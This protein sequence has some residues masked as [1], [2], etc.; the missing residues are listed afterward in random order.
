MTFFFE[1]HAVDEQKKKKKKK[2]DSKNLRLW[3]TWALCS[4]FDHFWTPLYGLFVME[5]YHVVLI[6]FS[7]F[8]FLLFFLPLY[9][10]PSMSLS[11]IVFT[12]EDCLRWCC[13]VECGPVALSTMCYKFSLVASYSHSKCMKT[14][15][16][17]KLIERKKTAKEEKE[18]E[19]ERDGERSKLSESRIIK[20]RRYNVNM[21][22]KQFPEF[23]F[24][25]MNFSI[26]SVSIWNERKKENCWW[27]R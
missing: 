24:W 5:V 8:F 15:L 26:T 12:V 4:C 16:F 6:C 11:V 1:W 7:D 19:E 9:F 20:R 10:S 23:L 18:K 2:K 22:L 21:C 27:T 3:W 17:T 25:F 13:R 14:K